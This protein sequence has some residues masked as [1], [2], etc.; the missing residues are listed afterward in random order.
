MFSVPRR[1]NYLKYGSHT[2][3]I[4]EEVR[5]VSETPSGLQMGCFGL[6]ISFPCF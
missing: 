6:Q 4:F 5:F 3:S 1:L 2:M